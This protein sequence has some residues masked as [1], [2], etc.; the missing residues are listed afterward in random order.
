MSKLISSISENHRFLASIEKCRKQVNL[1]LQKYL[2]IH[3]EFTDHSIVHSETVLDRAGDVLGN[4]IYSLNQSEIYILIMSCYLHD[5]GMTPPT[6][7]VKNKIFKSDEYKLL[8]E[9]TTYSEYVRMQHHKLSYEYILDNYQDLG[10]VN[11]RYAEAIAR[12]SMGHRKEELLDQNIFDPNFPVESGSN[13]ICLPFLSAVL[14]LSDELDITHERIPSLLYNKYF[15]KKLISQKEWR[16]HNSSLLVNFRDNTILITGE[17]NDVEIYYDLIN[18]YKKIEAVLNYT[19]KVITYIPADRNLKIDFTKLEIDIKPQGFVP[20]SIGFSFDLQNTLDTFIGKNIY[21][22]KYVAIRE[23]IQNSIDSCNYKKTLTPNFLPKIEVVLEEGKLIIRDNGLGMDE[24]IV[25]NFF[26][27]LA[28]S[29]Y[30][31]KEIQDKFESVSQFGV[32]VFSYFLLCNYF[33]VETK[34]ANKNPL[35]FKVTRDAKS[36]FSFSDDTS[37]VKEGTKVS[38]FLNEKMEFLELYDQVKHFFRFI[39]IPIIVR[40]NGRNEIVKCQNFDKPLLNNLK[41]LANVLYEAEFSNV[42]SVSTHLHT[43][44]YEGVCSLLIYK[45]KETKYSPRSLYEVVD[46]TSVNISQKGIYVGEYYGHLRNLLGKINLKRKNSLVLSRSRLK[47]DSYISSILSD[48]EFELVTK[49]FSK[50]NKLLLEDKSVLT[51]KFISNYLNSNGHNI[52]TN[53]VDSYLNNFTI[54][55]YRNEKFNFSSLRNFLINKSFLLVRHY[56]YWNWYSHSE[57]PSEENYRQ[58]WKKYKIPLLIVDADIDDGFFLDLFNQL[59]YGLSVEPESINWFYRVT[60]NK[61]MDRQSIKDIGRV[62]SLQ[63]ADKEIA[64]Y[65]HFTTDVICNLNHPIIDYLFKNKEAVL[66]NQLL[67]NLWRELLNLLRD[68]MFNL[69]VSG[70]DKPLKYLEGMNK[71]LT[72]INSI[73]KTNFLLTENDFSPWIKKKLLQ[74]KNPKPS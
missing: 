16:K 39:D 23:A 64:A 57:K 26:S 53:L 25:D 67:F 50:W 52:R 40:S 55:Y 71:L 17:C 30:V 59:N 9:K 56:E 74:S 29:Y 47:N 20:K 65:P 35:K 14:R 72:K 66:E 5:I 54:K 60:T 73:S 48:F 18:H 28:R 13:F 69:H 37:D 45:D 10:I 43:N 15:P 63:I 33:E 32:G 8:K 1:I 7:K 61:K 3:P 51:K 70:I 42:T 2:Q 22:S 27:C 68:F 24:F 4:N 12:V 46:D 19:R 31:Q 58:L 34:A 36:D 38:L 49:I 62:V 44:E 21:H 11:K 6:E 41:E